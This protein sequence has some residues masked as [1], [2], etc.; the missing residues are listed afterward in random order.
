MLLVRRGDRSRRASCVIEQWRAV[1]VPLGE[2]GID[3][4]PALLGFVGPN[5]QRWIAL[6]G[7]DQQPGVG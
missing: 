3:D 2:D 6:E 5:G 7:L 1:H 4:P